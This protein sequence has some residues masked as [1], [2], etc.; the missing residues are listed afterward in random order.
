MSFD[1]L[2][3]TLHAD[4]V[5][6]SALAD[7]FSTPLYVYSAS[8]IRENYRRLRS[9]FAPLRPALKYA[10]KA[11]GSLAILRLLKEEGAGFDLVSGGD[12]HR[13]MKLGADPA[14]LVFTG[15]GKTDFELAQALDAGIGWF[16]AETL[17]ELAALNR[18]AG[19]QGR[20]PAVALRL[21]PGVV[22]ET[23]PHIRT[24]ALEDKFGFPEEQARA[25]LRRPAE[26]ANLV[27]RGLHLHIGSQIPSGEDVRRALDPTLRLVEEFP[28]IEA[29]DL[30]GG[31]PVRYV[32]S[33]RYPSIEEYA[34]PILER[35]SHPPASRLHIHLE[36]GRYVLADAGVLVLTVLADKRAGGRRAVIVDGGMNVL[37]R[38]ALYGAAH[39]VL[40]I[41]VSRI[42]PE[43]AD[44]AGPVCESADYLA[45]D[46]AL[47]P[48]L[49]RGD[50]LAVLHAGAYGMVMA[51]NYNGHPLPAE[52]LV[53][54]RSYRLIRRRQT[55]ED[56]TAFEEPLLR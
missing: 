35:L 26:F 20:T 52:V 48:R 12:L 32:A 51:S 37:I 10:L 2:G 31:Y 24:G 41:R 9:A 36:P 28:A 54:D 27:L 22:V 53:D 23:H 14:Q 13:A 21:N 39:Q 46:A 1:Y 40:P 25:I 6:L 17:E 3:E 47:P 30:G 15:I 50:R 11:N 44:V 29:L 38:P 33:D 34:A 18:L 43:P 45:H 16:N 5:P 19:L 49:Q 4:R 7:Q 55:Y 8:R 56:L 42:A